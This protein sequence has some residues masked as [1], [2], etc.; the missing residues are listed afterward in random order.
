MR[1]R[2]CIDPGCRRRTATTELDHTYDHAHSGLTPT[3]NSGPNCPRDHALKHRGGWTLT[4]PKA[5]HFTWNSPLR[6]SYH[7]RG[8]PLIPDLPEPL[9]RSATTTH[10]PTG[11]TTLLTTPPPPS[12]QPATPFSAAAAPQPRP[13][14]PVGRLAA[15]SSRLVPRG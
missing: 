10:R 6:Q 2:H 1:D 7:T 3:T 14:R 12:G 5:G 4:Q 13:W 9:P 8:E 11:P 15:P